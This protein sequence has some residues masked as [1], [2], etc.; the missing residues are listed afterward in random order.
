M[1]KYEQDYAGW[2]SEQADRL[3]SGQIAQVDIEHI[4][5]ELEHIMGNERRELFSHL[6]VLVGHLLKWQFQPSNRSRSW[7]AS[8]EVQRMDIEQMLKESP[9]LKRF[10]SEKIQEA[11]PKAVK[12]AYVET[13]LPASTFPEECPY[14][15]EE[16]LADNFWPD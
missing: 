5:E 12:L 13:G 11:Y 14:S 9:S 8:I 16:I 10:V 2:A 1:H 7:A 3:R 4:A 15:T 6:R